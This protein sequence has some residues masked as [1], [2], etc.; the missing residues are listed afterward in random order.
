M[1]TRHGRHVRLAALL[2]VLLTLAGRDHNVDVGFALSAATGLALSATTLLVVSTGDPIRHLIRGSR[3]ALGRGLR[4]GL[5]R[6]FLL[7]IHPVHKF[8]F[9]ALLLRHAGGACRACSGI[10]PIVA[11]TSAL[12]ATTLV[13]FKAGKIAAIGLGRARGLLKR[14]FGWRALAAG[15]A[16]ALL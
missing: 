7:P 13:H 1:R 12:G 3:H 8:P 2:S 14:L 6:H 4:H 10:R 5:R 9:K 15:L 16:H 11:A